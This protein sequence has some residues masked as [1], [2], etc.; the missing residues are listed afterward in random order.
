MFQEGTMTAHRPAKSSPARA[1]TRKQ[2]PKP[3]ED[4]WPAVVRYAID[5]TPRTVRFC[6]IL[7]V[8]GVVLAALIVLRLWL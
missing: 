1:V 8:A 3:P 6:A 5:S 4:G 2:D 7:L